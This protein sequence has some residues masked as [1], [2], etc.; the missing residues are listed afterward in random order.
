MV[1][2][3]FFSFK[4]P[5]NLNFVS[6]TITQNHRLFPWWL[7]TLTA[8]EQQDSGASPLLL[9][10]EPQYRKATIIIDPSFYGYNDTNKERL[11][12]HELIHL[13]TN[14]Q[15]GFIQGLISSFCKDN[16]TR[17]YLLKRS[18]EMLEAET[19]DI[20]FMLEGATD[21]EQPKTNTET[22]PLNEK[23]E[24]DFP[25][26]ESKAEQIRQGLEEKKKQQERDLEVQDLY[27]RLKTLSL[28]LHGVLQ[29]RKGMNGYVNLSKETMDKVGAILDGKDGGW[30]K[31]SALEDVADFCHRMNDVR[32]MLTDKAN[33]A[34]NRVIGP[35]DAII[36]EE[37]L[38]KV[39][40]KT[41]F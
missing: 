18:E 28:T 33:F 16:Y 15:W 14:T 12:R 17:D 37:N 19:Q 8:L 13:T 26:T 27:N 30:G 2:F 38:H 41:G 4:S 31:S 1:K 32:G 7:E 23:K 5:E 29:E 6:N 3:H 9:V 25:P 39:L 24:E 20:L 34:R 35:H 10:S 22:T 40:N 21:K 11:L 36:S